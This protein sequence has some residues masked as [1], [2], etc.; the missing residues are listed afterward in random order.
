M[1]S[2]NG[3]IS[4]VTGPLC[5][6][7]TGYRWIHLTKDIDAELWCILW[8]APEQTFELT[9]E[10]PVFATPLRS[11]WRH[12]N[13]VHDISR[14]VSLGGHK[15]I[16]LIFIPA[17]IINY[18]HHEVWDAFIYPFP[19]FNGAV[20]HS[21]KWILKV[22][23]AE[24][25]VFFSRPQCVNISKSW[26]SVGHDNA[27][28]WRHNERDGVSDHRRLHC[29]FICWFRRRSK[30]TSRVRVTGL[31]AGNSPVAGKCFHLMTSS[32]HTQ[33]QWHWSNNIGYIYIPLTRLPSRM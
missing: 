18:I 10:T 6:E 2:S 24:Y 21:R 30:K 13:E 1:T 31:C 23:S 9:I 33:E 11:L 29:L 7:F 3:S 19:N 16:G 15:L 20:V 26:Y 28:Q 12:C 17:W 8:S 5:G 25:W 32:W 4:R 14:P 22:S 27:S